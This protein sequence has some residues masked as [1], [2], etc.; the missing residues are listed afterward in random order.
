VIA[1]EAVRVKVTV[2]MRVDDPV[3][4]GAW[5]GGVWWPA[6]DVKEAVLE[7]DDVPED[8]LARQKKLKDL[9]DPGGGPVTDRDG[10]I[11]PIYTLE[12]KLGHLYTLEGRHRDPETLRW[13]EPGFEIVD[14]TGSNP[15]TPKPN[16]RAPI[17]AKVII[18]DRRGTDGIWESQRTTTPITKHNDPKPETRRT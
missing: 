8:W 14:N 6:G 2:A 1:K 5:A 7:S 10:K 13:S 12:Q 15:R 16:P 4:K 9:G 11:L 18:V 3:F 17:T